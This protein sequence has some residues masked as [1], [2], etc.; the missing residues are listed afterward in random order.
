M[1][2]DEMWLRLNCKPETGAQHGEAGIVISVEK[3]VAESQY[4]KYCDE[5]HRDANG[6]PLQFR[7][8]TKAGKR[9]SSSG[10][11]FFAKAVYSSTR[12][13]GADYTR[14]TDIGRGSG[15]KL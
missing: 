3:R 7:N 4:P 8:E 15:A 1:R 2:K 6:K 11:S 14:V 12:S 13:R 5:R 9:H 10:M